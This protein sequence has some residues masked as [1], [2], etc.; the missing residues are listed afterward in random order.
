MYTLE[1]NLDKATGLVIAY[2]VSVIAVTE[3]LNRQCGHLLLGDMKPVPQHSLRDSQPT[4]EVARSWMQCPG[5]TQA[6]NFPGFMSFQACANGGIFLSSVFKK[7]CNY[8]ASFL[9][10]I[11]VSMHPHHCTAAARIYTV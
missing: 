4:A 5:A 6:F 7:S 11:R 2:F 9:R 8:F 10:H 3:H 1:S